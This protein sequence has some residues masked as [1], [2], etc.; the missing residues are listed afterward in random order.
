ME[1]LKQRPQVTSTSVCIS[2]LVMLVKFIGKRLTFI[3]L[4]AVIL[5]TVLLSFLIRVLIALT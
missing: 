4:A 1:Q 2:S 3:L 5:M